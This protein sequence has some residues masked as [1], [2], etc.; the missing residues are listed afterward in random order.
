M[1][2]ADSGAVFTLGKSYLS[3]NHQSYFFIKNDAIRRLICGRN[4]S[5]VVCGMWSPA[6]V[7]STC[8]WIE[9][10]SHK[11]LIPFLLVIRWLGITESGRLFVW[12]ENQFG[13]LGIGTSDIVTKPSCV[14]T[15]KALGER[16]RNVAFG[17][18]FAVIL[19]GI[20]LSAFSFAG[21]YFV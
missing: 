5:A 18:A 17:E 8:D 7:A 11:S 3:E 4:Q 2:R 19:T 15:I 14:K 6:V 1:C 13:Q 10:G 21:V 16:V 9:R 20:C 12:G